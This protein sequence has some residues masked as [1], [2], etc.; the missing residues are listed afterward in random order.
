MRFQKTYLSRSMTRA[1][2]MDHPIGDPFGGPAYG[3]RRDPVSAVVAVASM[4]YSYG[5]AAALIAGTTAITFGSVA[6]GVVFAGGALSLVG[7]VTGNKD[8]MKTGQTAMLL[9][10]LGGLADP[11]GFM[12]TAGVDI[13]KTGAD[14]ASV[15]TLADSG[16]TATSVTS[17]AVTSAPSVT[18]VAATPG[19]DVSASAQNISA[20]P[21]PSAPAAAPVAA[22]PAGTPSP[23]DVMSAPPG[24]ANTPGAAPSVLDQSNVVASAPPPVAPPPISAAPPPLPD[25]MASTPAAAVAQDNAYL[26]GNAGMGAPA[27]GGGGLIGDAISGFNKLDTTGKILATKVGADVVGGA[28][29]YVAP[30]P[31]QQAQ[32]NYANAAAA[33][34]NAA[35]GANDANAA[36]IRQEQALQQARI[37]QLNRNMQMGLGVGV[38]PNA[39]QISGPAQ[40]NY[41][42]PGL[43]QSARAT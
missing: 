5:G 27:A 1:M 9:G 29:G 25:A 42:I 37:D 7:N 24:G 36:K 34:A 4:A 10:G 21:P 17:D 40:T 11:S 16:S 15:S 19:G 33:N 12:G 28:V 6:A 43:I 38:N 23:T 2:A 31:Q 22:P 32:A 35:A 8:L 18:D 30:S 26:A 14:A 13:A 3:E 41:Q 39:V 20:P